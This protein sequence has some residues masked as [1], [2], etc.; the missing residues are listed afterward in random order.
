MKF[1][2]KT[3]SNIQ[4]SMVVPML[5]F[6]LE[7]PFLGYPFWKNLVQKNQNC[8]FELKTGTQTNSNMENSMVMFSVSDF[9]RKYPSFE[10]LFHKSKFFEAA[11]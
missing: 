1:D 11:I 10:N 7:I 6:R 5:C 4:N 3:H 2:A 9:D 8:Q